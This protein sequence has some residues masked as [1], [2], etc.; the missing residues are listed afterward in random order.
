MTETL[1]TQETFFPIIDA[2]AK[3]LEP[4]VRIQ[5]DAMGEPVD[6]ALKAFSDDIA[7]LRRH[8]TLRRH[9]IL[10]QDDIRRIE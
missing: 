3:R 5:A 7:S 10:D 4:E 9:F 2:L 6:A 8:L 1:Y